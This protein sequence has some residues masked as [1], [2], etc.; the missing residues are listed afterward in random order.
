MEGVCVA[1]EQKVGLG[2]AVGDTRVGSA[3]RCELATTAAPQQA[4]H[5]LPR[6]EFLQWAKSGHQTPRNRELKAEV[7]PP[8][9]PSCAR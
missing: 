3:V 1:T 5:L 2:A 8:L 4:D 7:T 6:S 9:H